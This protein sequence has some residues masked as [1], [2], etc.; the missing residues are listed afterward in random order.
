VTSTTDTLRAALADRYVIERELG[1]GGMATVYLARDL[2]HHR[3]VAVKVLHSELAAALGGGRFLKEIQ[4]AAHLQHP[5]ILTLIDSGEA[6]GFFYYVMPFVDGES[7]RSKL[8]REHELSLPES[9]RILRDV[10][11]ALSEAHAQGV[12]HRDIKPDNVLLRGQHAVVTDFGVAKAVSD[13]TGGA[14]N[15]TAGVALGTPSYMAPEQAAADAAT[16]HRADI[17]SFGVMAYEMLAGRP[18]FT[19]PTAHAVLSAHMTQAPDPITRHRAA[20]PAPLADLVMRCLEKKP[21]DRWQKVEE[22]LHQLDAIKT[23]ST[24]TAITHAVGGRFWSK[25]RVALI[26]AAVA[27]IVAL[28]YA[29]Q[30][31]R[32]S[33]KAAVARIPMLAVLPMVNLGSAEEEYFADG[34]TEELMGRLSKLSGL[35]VI[36]RTSTN[37]YKKTAKSIPQIAKELAA[38]YLIE[39]TVR[40]EKQPNGGRV[41]ITPR[42]V[43][44]KDGSTVWTEQ[45]DK[46][47]GSAIFDMQSDIA[48]RVADALSVVLLT[49]ERKAV[50]A[51]PTANPQA[52]DYFLRAQAVRDADDWDKQRAALQLY[53]AAVKLDPTFA[54]AHAGVANMHVIMSVG[55]D[56]SLPS[57]FTLERR[58]QLAKEAA[59]RALTLDPNLTRAHMVLGWYYQVVVGD[60]SRAKEQSK[61]IERGDPND[62]EALVD[63]GWMRLTTGDR[64]AGLGDFERAAT[65]DPRNPTRLRT[66]GFGFL[67]A[68]D[69]QSAE[70]YADRAIAVAPALAGGYVD[71]LWLNVEQNRLASANAVMREGA[72]HV[73][74]N[75]MLFQ[76]SSNSSTIRALRILAGDYGPA[77]K[78]I[79]WDAFGV[80]SVDYY[81]TKVIAF[82]SDAARARAY[83]DSL[84]AWAVARVRS[85]GT[86]DPTDA[87]M[88]ITGLAGS[89]Q[90]QVAITEINRLLGDPRPLWRFSERELLAEACVLAEHYECAIKQIKAA[91]DTPVP[92]S[93]TLLRIDPIWDPLRKLPEFQKLA[94]AR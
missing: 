30:S 22:I 8:S 6:A 84:A 81:L 80:D 89:G 58:G 41:R 76:V 7:L 19:G 56:S 65:L 59:E 1:R 25:T 52:Y 45:Y 10:A 15:T 12:V 16:D 40:W 13:A 4:I 66:V 87:I 14:H 35:N 17:Y 55:Y 70:A 90:H 2:K 92:L 61:Y 47:Y 69:Y 49:P 60:S 23:P 75:R 83:Y 71:K 50:T 46:P 91:M 62:P 18:P 63:R 39:A 68:K 21:A 27:V 82:R 11:D 43:R 72:R 85:R 20:V 64:A 24:G 51:K 57:G 32:M 26:V 74:L 88:W 77:L 53:E 36:A 29:L 9:V 5:H 42:L 44:A 48:E 34:M 28:G 3:A 38:D 67:A 37:Q 54:L 94:T 79:S 73:G 33:G 86:R 31:G 93:P 78:S